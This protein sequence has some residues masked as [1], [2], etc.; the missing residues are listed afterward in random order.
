[1]RDTLLDSLSLAEYTSRPCQE[2][3]GNPDDN[4]KHRDL[5]TPAQ[6]DWVVP[7]LPG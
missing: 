3:P 5:L 4:S 1:M 2:V 6:A 7:E